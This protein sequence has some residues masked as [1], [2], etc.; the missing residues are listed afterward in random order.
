MCVCVCVCVCVCIQKHAGKVGLACLL[1]T[2][3]R[4]SEKE[5]TVPQLSVA[6]PLPS[7]AIGGRNSLEHRLQPQLKRLPG[8]EIHPK[9][10]QATSPG[11]R[12]ACRCHF[13]AAWR[14]ACQKSGGTAWILPV[15]NFQVKVRETP[16]PEPP[17]SCHWKPP[18]KGSKTF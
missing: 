15:F 14:G 12:P 2:L 17:F 3:P 7:P 1:L 8:P 18:R 11:T 6:F 5:H 4:K 13:K 9:P 16:P 10:G